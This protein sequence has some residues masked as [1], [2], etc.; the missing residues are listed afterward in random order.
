MQILLL[1]FLEESRSH[2]LA[3][4]WDD[5]IDETLKNSKID[6]LTIHKEWFLGFA[7]L[8]NLLRKCNLSL[9]FRF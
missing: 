6:T 2:L 5:E 7:S 4:L 1:N 8:S 3:R 9:L